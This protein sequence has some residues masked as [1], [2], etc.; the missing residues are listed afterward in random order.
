VL[1]VAW[2]VMMWVREGDAPERQNLPAKTVTTDLVDG[3]ELPLT[4]EFCR[5]GVR[6]SGVTTTLLGLERM[7]LITHRRSIMTIL[8]R[9]GLEQNSNGAY[10]SPNHR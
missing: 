7:V 2:V 10:S 9:E 8:D 6:R 1:S 3:D 5:H 4:H